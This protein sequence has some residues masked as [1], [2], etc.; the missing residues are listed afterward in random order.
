MRIR[1]SVHAGTFMSQPSPASTA[2]PADPCC[3]VIFGASGNLTHRLLLPALYNLAAAHLLPQAF[4]IIGV[5]RG[6][7]SNDAFRGDLAE[8]L[9][10]FALRKVEQA[11]ADRL[12]ACARYLN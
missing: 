9:R 4:S 7:M 8:G 11:T 2:R 6:E 5:A 1:F 12:L 3:F 10:R